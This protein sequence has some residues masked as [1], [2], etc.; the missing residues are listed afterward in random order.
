MN[1]PIIGYNLKT[2]ETRYFNS[3]TEA[4]RELGLVRDAAGAVARKER[5]SAQGWWF[6]FEDDPASPPEFWGEALRIQKTS[7]AK[8]LPIIAINFETGEERRY[9]SGTAGANDLSLTLS[10]VSGIARGHNHSAAGWWFKFE[11]DDREMPK[12]FGHTAAWDKRSRTVYA[13]NLKTGEKR[14]F[15]NC[16]TADTELG[17]SKGASRA[18]AAGERTSARDWWFTYNE[19]DTPPTAYKGSLVARKRSNPVIAEDIKTGETFEFGSGKAAAAELGV[20]RST[21]SEV[22]SGKRKSAKGYRFRFAK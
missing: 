17:L 9:K 19:A 22:I 11:G 3:S 16:M 10:T 14:N 13:V 6:K 18:V 1:K 5:N 2:N 4:S 21:I 15:R 20:Q 8:S 12:S 7:E